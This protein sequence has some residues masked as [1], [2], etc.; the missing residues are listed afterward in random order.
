MLSTNFFRTWLGIHLCRRAF[1]SVGSPRP[2]IRLILIC[3]MVPVILGFTQYPQ[4]S[5]VFHHTMFSP[6][7]QTGVASPE[8]PAATDFSSSEHQQRQDFR[9][10]GKKTRSKKDLQYIPPEE[11]SFH[12]LII[13][14]FSP[15]LIYM[16]YFVFSEKSGPKFLLLLLGIYPVILVY[17]LNPKWRFFSYHGLLH[18]SIHYQLLHWHL[19]PTMPFLAG[20]PLYYSWGYEFFS[21]LIA[22]IFNLAP[23]YCFAL[24]N[25]VSL[26]L[27]MILSY[28][29]SQM[30]IANEKLNIFSV[31]IS[32]FAFSIFLKVY[33]WQPFP[34]LGSFLIE[35]VD[36]RVCPIIIKFSNV[37]GVPIGL[38]FF[39]LFLYSLLHLILDQRIVPSGI[40]FVLSILACAFVYTPFIPGI[41][42]SAVAVSFLHLCQAR[43]TP[44]IVRFRRSALIL[45]LLLLSFL[46]LGPYFLTINSGVKGKLELFN[47]ASMTHALLTYFTISLPILIV[48]L[49]SFKFI[50]VNA[51]YRVTTA[52]MTVVVVNFICYSI[53]HL[54]SA[55]EYKFLILSIV[56]LGILGGAAFYGLR[57]RFRRVVVLVLLLP[58]LFPLYCNIDRKVNALKD[59]ESPFQEQ[60]KYIYHSG[61]E[62]KALYHWITNQTPFDSVFID[63]R[64]T[65]PLLG[66]RQLL[67]ARRV[68]E[69]GGAV[70]PFYPGFVTMNFFL[71]SIVAYDPAL[72]KNRR[73]LVKRVY[74]AKQSLTESDIQYLRKLKKKV[75]V[76]VTSKNVRQ[77]LVRYPFEPVYTSPQDRYAVYQL[78]NSAEITVSHVL[79]R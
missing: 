59:L 39:L 78:A 22:S 44:L 8:D 9:A 37:N 73:R 2:H 54:P 65:L 75:Y 51:N 18:T 32:I 70:R 50:K 12:P 3:S 49:M 11:V 43:E 60:G 61:S 48:I 10:A 19:P 14:L 33:P 47:G 38:L 4:W 15:L 56:P 40:Y 6:I 21:V 66:R 45:A 46:L 28:K 23:S 35:H 79:K 69:P 20:E 76:I 25:I 63:S 53:I 24:I 26:L 27:V 30:M 31:V 55:N 17:V 13:A 29:I 77:K 34:A 16:V 1:F 7:A 72:L 74:S 67:I 5:P 58:F 62:E 36:P 41:L 52:I 64:F 42:V 71:K 68:N 57:E